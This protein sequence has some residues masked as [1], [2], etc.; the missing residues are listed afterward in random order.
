ML[1]PKALAGRLSVAAGGLYWVWDAACS[2][3]FTVLWREEARLGSGDLCRSHCAPSSV[4]TLQTVEV[5]GLVWDMLNL[6]CPVSQ[7]ENKDSQL[8]HKSY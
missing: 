1:E 2:S 4:G 8:E 7:V 6:A 3:D 5:A